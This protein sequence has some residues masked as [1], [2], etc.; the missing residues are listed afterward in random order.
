VPDEDQK[1]IVQKIKGFNPVFP[2]KEKD[3]DCP[4]IYGQFTNW[5]PRR[6]YEIKEFCDKINVNKPNLFINCQ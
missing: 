6:M 2:E 5:K 4:Y 1:F 3:R